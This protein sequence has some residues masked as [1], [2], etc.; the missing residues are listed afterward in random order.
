M[1]VVCAVQSMQRPADA[2]RVEA[3]PASPKML[4]VIVKVILQ[5]EGVLVDAA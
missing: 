4:L 5:R 2:D 1:H 3:F